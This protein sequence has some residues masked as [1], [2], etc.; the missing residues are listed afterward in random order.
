MQT[1]HHP[2]REEAKRHHPTGERRRKALP[3]NKR[4]TRKPASPTREREKTAP[5]K[6]RGGKQQ[7]QKKEE[8]PKGGRGGLYHQKEE[9]K[10]AR[11]RTRGWESRRWAQDEGRP[12]KRN[13]QRRSHD[14]REA[15][16]RGRRALRHGR[17]ANQGCP[18][19]IE[20]KA[21]REAPTDHILCHGSGAAPARTADAE[22][23]LESGKEPTSLA[24]AVRASR[25]RASM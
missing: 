4:R 24:E 13:Q 2:K 14:W 21:E 9:E 6:G 22:S 19:H 1:Q 15:D 5:P 23:G 25:E 11:E 10:A 20:K 8:A 16:C 7:H 18:H 12:T 3:Y 17:S